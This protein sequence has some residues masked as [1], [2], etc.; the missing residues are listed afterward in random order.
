MAKRARM[1][2][3]EAYAVKTRQSEPV[4]SRGRGTLLLERKS[5]GAILCFYRE[6]TAFS[7]KRLPLGI[8]AKK[9]KPG[10]DE[11]S[12]D[13][14]RTDASRIASD[15]VTAGGLMQYLELQ[16]EREKEN[17]RQRLKLQQQAE[18]QAKRGSFGEL[19]EAYTENLESEGKAS[20]RKIKSLFRVNVLEAHPVLAARYANEI[21]PHEI[22]MILDAVLSRAPKPRGIGRKAP[23][24]ITSMTSTADELRRYLRTA[25]NFA[26]ASHLAAGKKGKNQGKFFALS[27]NPAALIPAIKNAA[28]GNTES[29]SPSELGEILRHLN[30]LEDRPSAI[31][32]AL[33]YLGG[34]RIKQL[35]AVKWEDLT[36]ETISLLDAKGKK[37]EAWEH[38]LPL[39]PRILEV[40]A[41]LLSDPIGPGPFSLKPGRVAHKDT[42]SHLF[43]RASSILA[44]QGKTRPFSW[45]EVRA[46]V[47]TL[48]AAQGVP[49]EV[50]AWL[51]S[52]GRSGVQKKHYDRFAYMPQKQAALEQWGRYLDGLASGEEQT[53]NVVL[54]SRR[55]RND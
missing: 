37:S 8:L 51:L 29:L 28:G 41:P 21:Q 7:D 40:L 23:A 22:T 3:M 14:M 1:T 47:E 18:E 27:G 49:P 13:E 45:Q 36:E 31:A 17:E 50:R 5:S 52:H 30:S 20:A 39:T 44:P 35:L 12:L 11:R 4:G 6:R 2:E 34:Q 19:L 54:L 32:K 9:P 33:I 55:K 43:T 42:I 25:F 46:T 10:T 26:A 38:L 53:D 24:P 15:C 48:M 16:A